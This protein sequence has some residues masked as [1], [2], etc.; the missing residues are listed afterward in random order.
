MSRIKGFELDMM[1]IYF[2]I[3]LIMGGVI[4]AVGVHGHYQLEIAKLEHNDE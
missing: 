3:V 1:P 4:A 2:V